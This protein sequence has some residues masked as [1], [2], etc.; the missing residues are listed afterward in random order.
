MLARSIQHRRSRTRREEPT[1][2]KRFTCPLGAADSA[3]GY[4]PGGRKFESSRGCCGRGVPGSC[5]PDCGSGGTGSSPVGH[6]ADGV[7]SVERLPSKQVAAGSSPVIRSRRAG[8]CASLVGACARARRNPQ[9]RP[10]VLGNGPVARGATLC[11]DVACWS[12]A[13]LAEWQ[14]R[15]FQKPVSLTDVR[16]QVSRWVLAVPVRVRLTRVDRLANVESLHVGPLRS[17][18]SNGMWRSW[19]RT[20]LG[21]RGSLVRVQSS[22]LVHPGRFPHPSAHLLLVNASP[23]IDRGREGKGC[24]TP[25]STGRRQGRTRC[26]APHEQRRLL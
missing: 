14:T 22:R 6:P 19:Q 7:R 26:G 3:P 25:V 21:D 24:D 16:V 4:E 2:T 1:R 15:R 23:R 18:A 8:C 11:H 17:G 10:A 13:H 20:G 12:L 5:T 9:A